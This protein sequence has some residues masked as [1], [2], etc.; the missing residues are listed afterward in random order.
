MSELMGRNVSVTLPTTDD[1][2][3]G[4]TLYGFVVRSNV[5][6]PAFDVTRFTDI[7]QRFSL[8]NYGGRMSITFTIDAASTQVPRIPSGTVVTV[9]VM[10]GIASGATDGLALK[11]AVTGWDYEGNNQGGGPPQRITYDFIV[12]PAPTDAAGTASITYT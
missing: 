4:L 12:T 11:C 3:S 8:G 2:A 10:P 7:G 6:R 9:T 1:F 5:S